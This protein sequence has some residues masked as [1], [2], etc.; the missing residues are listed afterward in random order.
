MNSIFN[1]HGYSNNQNLYVHPLIPTN[2]LDLGFQTNHNFEDIEFNTLSTIY[3]ITSDKTINELNI[4]KEYEGKLRNK[5]YCGFTK[6]KFINGEIYEGYLKKGKLNGKGIITKNDKK[7]YEGNFKNNLYD[8]K[9]IIY[10]EDE[11]YSVN[12]YRG[13]FKNGDATGFGKITFY[14][15]D[16]YY[17]NIIKNRIDGYGEYDHIDGYC[18]KGFFK[19]GRKNGKGFINF[20]DYNCYES[21]ML[22]VSSDDWN[23]GYLNNNG[24]IIWNSGIIYI[25][26]I[27]TKFKIS[28]NNNK[29]FFCLHG[30][31]KLYYGSKI[32][33]NGDYHDNAKE[34]YGISYYDNGKISYEGD[35]SHDCRDGHGTSYSM[36]NSSVIYTGKWKDGN[37]HGE[38]TLF[39]SN[40]SASH[41]NF[42]FGKKNGKFGNTDKYLKT[43]SRYYYKGNRISVKFSELNDNDEKFCSIC[44]KDYKKSDLI[45][46]LPNCNHFYHGECILKWLNQNNSCPLCRETNILEQFEN[47]TKRRRI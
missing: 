43:C 44:H 14:N 46:K 45:V 25:G 24:T 19:N 23:D 35:F 32:I 20:N 1:S 21:R 33:Y 22:Q 4:V 5:L 27:V 7:I 31:G 16:T 18:Y 38:G 47:P 41:G 6:I 17:G 3:K 37:F 2:D 34:G 13:Q 28:I 42:E 40:G 11:E 39:Y 26:Q 30:Q 10:N 29:L 9:G 8:G 12:H 15:G 36:D